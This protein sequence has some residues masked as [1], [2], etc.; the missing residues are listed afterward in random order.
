MFRLFTTATT[1]T[2]TTNVNEDSKHCKPRF[3][4]CHNSPKLHPP[5]LERGCC[6]QH[7]QPTSNCAYAVR[8]LIRGGGN[9]S[10][11]NMS[12]EEMC[13][14]ILLIFFHRCFFK[15]HTFFT[16]FPRGLR[17]KEISSIALPPYEQ[18]NATKS[19]TF[20]HIFRGKAWF[21]SKQYFFPPN[22]LNMDIPPV[23]WRTDSA[24]GSFDLKL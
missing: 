6:G 23:T 1:T 24:R 8:R 9:Y 2:T 3:H 5:K 15:T 21:I 7:P 11:E 18:Q 20:S 4:H 19:P 22:I 17:V 13:A 12:V 14:P 16:Y 10:H